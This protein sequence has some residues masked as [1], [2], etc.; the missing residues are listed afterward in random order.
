MAHIRQSKPHSGLDRLQLDCLIPPTVLNL[1]V[2][3]HR[4]GGGRDRG[5]EEGFQED[6]GPGGVGVRRGQRVLLRQ[7]VVSPSPASNNL[8]NT[9]GM[10]MSALTSE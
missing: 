9:I 7:Q 4:T 5:A 8:K 6:D 1:T 2:L 10:G 3:V